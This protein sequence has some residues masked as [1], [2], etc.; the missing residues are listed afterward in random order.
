MY[1]VFV[2]SPLVIVNNVMLMS[3]VLQYTFRYRC[4]SA[5][6]NKSAVWLNFLHLWQL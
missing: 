4:R 6:A 5:C 2:Y 1:A 3:C